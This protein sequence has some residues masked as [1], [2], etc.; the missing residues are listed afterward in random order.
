MRGEKVSGV[1]VH[2]AARV[3]ASAGVG[4]IIIAD[5]LQEAA[6]DVHAQLGDRGRH[7]LKGVPGEWQLFVVEALPS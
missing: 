5:S 6:T 2:V 1:A 4:E 3:M 7:E